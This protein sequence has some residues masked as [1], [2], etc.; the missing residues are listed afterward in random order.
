MAER[1]GSVPATAGDPP[2]EGGCAYACSVTCGGP[3]DL[4]TGLDSM[5]EVARGPVKSQDVCNN[6]ASRLIA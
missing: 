5:Y 3:G 6:V 1:S 4:R 2:V